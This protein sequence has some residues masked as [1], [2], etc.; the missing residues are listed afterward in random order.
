MF[1][2]NARAINNDATSCVYIAQHMTKQ[3][4]ELKLIKRV[5]M[6]QT[7]DNGHKVLSHKGKLLVDSEE[8]PME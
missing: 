3:D 8:V 5:Q 4:N 6:R 1:I 2:K 7:Y